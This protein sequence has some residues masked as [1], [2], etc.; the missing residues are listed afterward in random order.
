MAGQQARNTW[1]LQFSAF[2]EKLIM[3]CNFIVLI[4]H[5]Y[6][7]KHEYVKKL[8][9]NNTMKQYVI[10]NRQKHCELDNNNSKH[11][12][13]ILL[14]VND[15]YGAVTQRPVQVHSTQNTILTC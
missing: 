5:F 15:F 14:Y 4:L 6:D 9:G 10:V 11:S 1:N 7:Q 2:A 13:K 8:T 12:K 3:N